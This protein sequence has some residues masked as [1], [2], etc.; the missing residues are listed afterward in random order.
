[1]SLSKLFRTLKPHRI[2]SVHHQ[3]PPQD[4]DNTNRSKVTS[5][6][7]RLKKEYVSFNGDS[8]PQRQLSRLTNVAP[9]QQQ[10]LLNDTNTR[11]QHTDD[12]VSVHI[13][14]DDVRSVSINNEPLLDPARLP[15]V[16][17]NG[18]LTGSD[19]IVMESKANSIVT[20]SSKPSPVTNRRQ[21]VL[22][23]L[24][25]SGSSSNLKDNSMLFHLVQPPTT[26][27]QASMVS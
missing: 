23:E 4:S 2:K 13:A 6:N 26:S 19:Q 25:S 9:N 22:K 15:P 21:S 5:A 12:R 10:E 24:K 27:L 7:T 17:N 20:S 3:N 1:M 14:C 18:G 16:I 8:I 11:V